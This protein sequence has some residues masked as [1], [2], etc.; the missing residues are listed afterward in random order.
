MESD[1]FLFSLDQPTAE[2]G[3]GLCCGSRVKRVVTKSDDTKTEQGE[4]TSVEKDKTSNDTLWVA[5][6]VRSAVAKVTT[7]TW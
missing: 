7:S 5:F 4:V 2:V 1:A 6:G 3:S